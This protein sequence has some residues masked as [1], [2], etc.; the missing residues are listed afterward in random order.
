V[1]F[2]VEFKENETIT[3]KA[4]YPERYALPPEL[5][6]NPFFNSKSC[7]Y[8][9]KTGSAWNDTI[10]ATFTFKINKNMLPIGL[11]GF[12]IFDDGAYIVATKSYTNW[13]PDRDI[14]IEWTV[15]NI[16][17]LLVVII[18]IILI[19]LII[20]IRRKKK[21]NKQNTK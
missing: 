1:F 18:P 11:S 9:A 19:I 10:N 14:K 20:I 16:P 21:L 5:F 2:N 15:I 4:I 13:I 8:I 6:D 17:C 3:L 12:D 7:T